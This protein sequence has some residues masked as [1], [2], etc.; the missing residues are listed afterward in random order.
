MLI[1]KA[2]ADTEA[3]IIPSDE[4]MQA[5]T[6]YN[7]EMIKAGVMLDGVG[8]RSSAEGMRV[9]VSDRRVTDGPF[10]ETKELIAGFTMIEVS[11]PEEALAWAKRWPA[12]DADA[13]IEVR[14][15]HEPEDFGA[16]EELIRAQEERL[17][18]T[19]EPGN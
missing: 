12:I 7:E 2:D 18:Q 13:E 9:R 17:R 16:N 3:G 15:V 6:A 1:R 8:L 11:S 19:D 14:R 10:T 5:M 4:F